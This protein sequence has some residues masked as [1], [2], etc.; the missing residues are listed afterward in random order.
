LAAFGMLCEPCL[1][2]WTRECHWRTLLDAWPVG[3]ARCQKAGESSELCEICWRT[4]KGDGMGREEMLALFR[5]TTRH[6]RLDCPHAQAVVDP[7]ARAVAKVMRWPLGERRVLASAFLQEVG[8]AMVTGH[9]AEGRAARGPFAVVVAELS[10]VLVERQ[11]RN[12]VSTLPDCDAGEAYGRVRAAVEG[13]LRHSWREALAREEALLMWLQEMPEKDLPTDEW[14]KAWNGF[15]RED[16]G[17]M[18]LDF[19]AAREEVPG[20]LE[21]LPRAGTRVLA[22][23]ECHGA[24]VTLQLRAVT[25]MGASAVGVLSAP[26]R[27]LMGEATRPAERRPPEP[28][29]ELLRRGAGVVTVY[30]DGSGEGACGWGVVVV[31]GGRGGAD[32][33]ARL[34][35]E[36]YGPLVLARDA[37][38]F[39]G[40]EKASN[41]T[42]E[43]TALA[44]GLAYLREEEGTTGPAI[45]RPDSEYAMDIALGLSKP[46]KNASLA[47]QVRR[48][49][50]EEEERRGGQLW[51]VHVKAHQGHE[52]NERADRAAA[53]GSAGFVR[54]IGTRWHLWP[55]LPTREPRA[56]AVSEATRVLRATHAFG[57]LGMPVPVHGVVPESTVRARLARVERRLEGVNGPRAAVA[58]S[59]AR[60]AHRLLSEPTRQRAEARRLIAAGLQPTTSELDCPVNLRALEGYVTRAGAEADVVQFDKH[61][62]PRGT[63]RELARIFVAR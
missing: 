58:M 48:L 44:E 52:W 51:A 49:W 46:K 59:R 41:N 32:R 2:R 3:N 56:H 27:V 26:A 21:A 36:R 1:P 47:A 25:V 14:R 23:V 16:A 10:R 18:W 61:G 9:R 33:T 34:V 42:A 5:E 24:R 63:L 53:R 54:G 50:K 19:P 35:T 8:A 57:A 39:I 31:S 15:Y 29:P 45:V 60:A 28:P 38:P 37:P 13:I 30:V 55:P 17:G 40:A 62:Q 7:V 43:L 12:A 11:R 20:A 6:V 4:G 22:G